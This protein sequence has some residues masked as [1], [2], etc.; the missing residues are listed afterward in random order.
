M[1]ALLIVCL[2]EM[3]TLFYGYINTSISF[4]SVSQTLKAKCVN[5]LQYILSMYSTY[6]SS[7][8]VD[9]SRDNF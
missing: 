4:T 2:S 8:E 7:L 6:K 5:G 9:Y 3:V 1:N